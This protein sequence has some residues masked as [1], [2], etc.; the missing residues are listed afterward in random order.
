MANSGVQAGVWLPS[1]VASVRNLLDRRRR[2]GVTFRRHDAGCGLGASLLATKASVYTHGAFFIG[3]RGGMVLLLFVTFLS[4][5]IS[6]WQALLLQ[7]WR[8]RFPLFQQ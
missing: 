1:L 6:G 4:W 8:F 5:A 3:I 7:F 2:P